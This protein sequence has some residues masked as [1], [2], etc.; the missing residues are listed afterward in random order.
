MFSAFQS[1]AYQNNAFQIVGAG[2]ATLPPNGNG[3]REYVPTYYE[4]ENNR[5]KLQKYKDAEREAQ[6]ELLSIEYKIEDLELKRLRDLAD[7]AMQLQLI[8][9]LKEQQIFQQI[10][11]ELQIQKEKLRRDEDDILILLMSMPFNA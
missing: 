3:R 8:G 9:L 7:E 4:L 11:R 1:T 5:K 2:D 6:I 10:L